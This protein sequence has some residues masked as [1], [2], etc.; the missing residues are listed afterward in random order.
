M[1]QLTPSIAHEVTQPITAAVTNAEA[2]LRWLGAQPPDLKE[3]REALG[4]I[5]KDGARA[6]NV[7]GGIRALIKKGPPQQACLDINEA[8]REVIALTRG[9][10]AKTRV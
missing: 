2:A 6:S 4:L 9:E 3:V 10:A 1:G 8:I 7:M 5:V